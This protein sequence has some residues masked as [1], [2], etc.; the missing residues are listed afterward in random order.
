MKNTYLTMF[1]YIVNFVS[2][3]FIPIRRFGQCWQLIIF[4][5]TVRGWWIPFC[6]HYIEYNSYYYHD[7]HNPHVATCC[8][9]SDICV[10]EIY[11]IMK[12]KN[13]IKK[14]V[15]TLNTASTVKLYIRVLTERH[16]ISLTIN[17]ILCIKMIIKYQLKLSLKL[18]L[19]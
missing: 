6:L 5:N 19:N 8:N 7:H 12:S 16:T 10:K 11:P 18:K 4:S 9:Q 14:L 15:F 3:F 17:I 13:V 2:N 1:G